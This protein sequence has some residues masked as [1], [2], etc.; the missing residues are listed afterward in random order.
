MLI[1]PD[2]KDEEIIACLQD[3]Y[4]LSV[5]KITF[6][7]IGADFNTAVYRMT[8]SNQTDYFL[9]LRS[10]EFLEVSVSV[11]K[12][13]ADLGIKQVIPPLATKTGHLWTNLGDFTVTLY[14]YIDGCNGV[15]T[16]LSKDQWV[17]FGKPLRSFEKGW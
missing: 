10:D 16:K 11:P 12:Y 4:G 9:K 13:L 1:K 15:D 7:P 6:L 5:E 17:Q 14:P 2:L 3:A 8:K